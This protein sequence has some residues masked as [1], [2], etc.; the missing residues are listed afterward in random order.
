MF[1]P[2]INQDK[3]DNCQECVKICPKL[4]LECKPDKISVDNAC[5]CTG[6]ESC[7]AVCPFSAIKVEDM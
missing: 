7:V 2:K 5:A 6:C 3:C 4:V 1:I